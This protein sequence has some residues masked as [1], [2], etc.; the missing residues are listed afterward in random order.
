MNV[1]RERHY[2]VVVCPK[3]RIQTQIVEDTGQK[4]VRCQNC[5]AT[6]RFRKLRQFHNSTD[7]E[8]AIIAR[9]KLQASLA[10]KGSSSIISTVE[11]DES[12]I[13]ERGEDKTLPKKPLEIVLSNIPAGES[14]SHTDLKNRVR[15]MGLDGEIFEITMCKLLE[16]GHIYEPKNGIFRKA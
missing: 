5:G 6:L 13:K 2:V 14:I 12:K 4:T 7:L 15:K 8:E 10:G 3:C 16:A 11:V 1:D 9:T